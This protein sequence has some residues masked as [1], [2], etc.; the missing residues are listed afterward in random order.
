[1]TKKEL[2]KTWQT[3]SVEFRRMPQ[4]KLCKRSSRIYKN[5]VRLREILL[6]CRM[7][8]EK[9]ADGKQVAFNTRIFRMAFRFY[10]RNMKQY[11]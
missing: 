9:I 5:V 11:T 6:V 3:L 1:M 10:R 2:T 7:F 8:L 4:W